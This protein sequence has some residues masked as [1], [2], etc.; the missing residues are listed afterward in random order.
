MYIERNGIHD[1]LLPIQACAWFYFFFFA[2]LHRYGVLLCGWM[3]SK[4]VCVLGLLFG[5]GEGVWGEMETWALG[6]KG[7]SLQ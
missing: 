4:R 3:F 7:F 6:V 1:I 5:G 2:F